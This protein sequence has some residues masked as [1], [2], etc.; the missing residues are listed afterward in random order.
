MS[1]AHPGF[2]NVAKGIAAKEGMPLQ[3]AQAILAAKTRAASPAARKKN[4]RL[5]NVAGR[6]L[7]KHFGK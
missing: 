6:I 1:N 7:K 2:K 5:N 4:P 3:Q